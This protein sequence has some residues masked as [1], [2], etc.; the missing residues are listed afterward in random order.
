MNID[1][2]IH[3]L[4]ILI[5]TWDDRSNHKK[6]LEIFLK[7]KLITYHGKKDSDTK[8]FIDKRPISEDK[9]TNLKIQ[10]KNLIKK[11]NKYL[12]PSTYVIGKPK[13]KRK[14]KLI[15]GWPNGINK[16]ECQY[17]II[18]V[19]NCEAYQSN[20][21]V[22]DHDSHK[23]KILSKDSNLVC[24]EEKDTIE[25]NSAKLVPVSD[26]FELSTLQV[27]D[28]QPI[29][30]N[31]IDT[32]IVTNIAISNKFAV[33]N[34]TKDAD[35]FEQNEFTNNDGISKSNNMN[36]TK[37]NGIQTRRS[38]RTKKPNRK[39]NDYSLTPL[40]QSGT[41]VNID[42]K[43]RGY[44]GNKRNYAQSFAMVDDFWS[45]GNVWTCYSC[46][47]SFKLEFAFRNHLRKHD[48]CNQRYVC[49][50]CDNTLKLLDVKLHISNSRKCIYGEAVLQSHYLKML[51]KT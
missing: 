8:T 22:D 51:D 40:K 12:L 38:L 45:D 29:S 30:T 3:D 27:D 7:D 15:M 31:E 14:P 4:R 43:N 26:K 5:S 11:S 46:E 16:N 21:F 25:S 50:T 35:M 9:Q 19:D 18:T 34:D 32:S 1:N 49:L 13:P 39:Y 44:Y 36:L 17:E 28:E 48:S 47:A 24:S 2:L 6:C 33:L 37:P 42:T 20:N 23:V 41:D 10:T